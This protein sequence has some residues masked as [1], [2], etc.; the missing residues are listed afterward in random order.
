MLFQ[1]GVRVLRVVV[2]GS[3]VPLG[4][5]RACTVTCVGKGS[6]VSSMRSDWIPPEREVMP[7]RVCVSCQPVCA[8]CSEG[9]L[10]VVA[11]AVELL[12]D[13]S[14]SV[15]VCCPPLGRVAVATT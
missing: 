8:C 4:M 10:P 14:S 7:S 11:R 3:Y 1:A 6:R 2:L 12:M 13:P 9:W 15:F 5:L